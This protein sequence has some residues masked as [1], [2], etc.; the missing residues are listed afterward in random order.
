MNL[1]GWHSFVFLGEGLQFWI[2][3]APIVCAG[4]AFAI[5]FIPSFVGLTCAQ[6]K[7]TA[8]RKEAAPEF[9]SPENHAQPS[10]HHDSD[11]DPGLSTS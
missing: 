10:E 9:H 3:V 2:I 11:N 1:H 7:G 6:I 4:V 8:W 5:V